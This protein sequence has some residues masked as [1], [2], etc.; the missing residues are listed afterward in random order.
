MTT[1][2]IPTEIGAERL[3]RPLPDEFPESGYLVF[4]NDDGRW[5][6]L[7]QEPGEDDE[8]GGSYAHRDEVL[9]A[10]ATDWEQAGGVLAP[11]FLSVVR[12]QANRGRFERT[13]GNR[14]PGDE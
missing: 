9:A 4:Q 8:I 2:V 1:Y 11:R 3:Y 5:M 13:R 14:E 7:Y 12:G 10:I 6:W